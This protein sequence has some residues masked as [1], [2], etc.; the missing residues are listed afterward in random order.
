MIRRTLLC[1]AQNRAYTQVMVE[2]QA[3]ERLPQWTLAD[4]LRKSLEHASVDSANMAEY[5]EVHPNTVRNWIAGRTNPPATAVKLWAM[6]CGLPYE[7]LAHGVETR[8][9]VA[10]DFGPPSDVTNLDI[11]SGMSVD[12]TGPP[13]HAE[14]LAH[15]KAF[16]LKFAA[17]APLAR[18]GVAS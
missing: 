8:P 9:A 14:I 11:P 13:T 12:Q 16:R 1:H 17:D 2:A 18:T 4:R 6:R 15:R 3:R 5:L 7:W 10:D